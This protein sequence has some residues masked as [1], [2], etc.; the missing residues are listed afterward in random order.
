M[1]EGVPLYDGE[2]DGAQVG[3]ITSGGFGPS[4][5]AP[6]A[7]GYADADHTQNGTTLWGEVRGKRMGVEVVSLPF[8]PARF[9]R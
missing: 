6:V 9:K 2:D 1:R 3:A 8:V 7:M 4:V 5:E